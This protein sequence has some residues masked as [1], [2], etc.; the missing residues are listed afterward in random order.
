[1]PRLHLRLRLEAWV[2][3]RGVTS[4]EI[5][6]PHSYPIRQTVFPSDVDDPTRDND[7]GRLSKVKEQLR[8][9]RSVP[10]NLRYLAR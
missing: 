9:S 6:Y 2:Q 7:T 10:F 1:M 8:E 3:K 4:E 5:A